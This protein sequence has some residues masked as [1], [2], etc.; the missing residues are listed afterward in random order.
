M[1]IDVH[2]LGERLGS[3]ESI[4][5][6]NRAISTLDIAS[7]VTEECCDGEID[8]PI[9]IL[10]AGEQTEGKGRDGRTWRSPRNRGVWATLMF[11]T[12]SSK[13]HLIPLEIGIVT[14]TFVESQG[15][16]GAGLKWPNDLIADGSKLAGILIRG[17]VNGDLT[18]VSAGIGINVLPLGEDRLN[19]TSI[20]ELTGETP[21]LDQILEA[22]VL[23]FDRWL[24]SL[25][26][27]STLENWQ[28]R[29]IHRDGD[30]V[31][32]RRNS[33]DLRGLWRGL[34]SNGRAL[35]EIDGTR[36]AVASGEFIEWRTP[37]HEES[38]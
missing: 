33:T 27:S 30:E 38:A 15:V 19:A 24:G 3:F 22:F 26:L 1:T 5:F 4:V 10:L 34:D 9:A 20:E 21:N 23:H 8:S 16:T 11:S 17:R 28:K 18:L 2:A 36:T 32:F 7:A 29:T 13:A 37:G 31:R 25:D 12:E 6:M 35:V 14:Q